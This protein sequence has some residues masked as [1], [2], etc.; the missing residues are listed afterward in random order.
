MTESTT[1]AAVNLVNSPLCAL[2]LTTHI[3][4]LHGLHVEDSVFDWKE[5]SSPALPLS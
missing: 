3:D 4:S 1:Y 5:L 2:F